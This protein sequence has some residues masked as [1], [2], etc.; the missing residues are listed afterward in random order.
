[1]SE[2]FLFIGGSQDKEVIALPKKRQE[3]R[4]P[5]YEKPDINITPTAAFSYKVEKYLLEKMR[6]QTKSYWIYR[7]ESLTTDDVLTMLLDNY[8]KRNE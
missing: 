1:M 8:A 4:F 5:V 3:V 2:S 6:S 7:H